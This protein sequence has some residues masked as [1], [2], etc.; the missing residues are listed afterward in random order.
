MKKNG[1]K[2]NYSIAEKVAYHKSRVQFPKV[3]EA[4]RIYSKNFLNGVHDEHAK[5]NLK[6]L[7]N[8][9]LKRDSANVV[10]G[11]KARLQEEKNENV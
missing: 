3:K 10:N 11:I 1:K 4:Q 8:E 7:K 6:D 5:S 2:K 9:F